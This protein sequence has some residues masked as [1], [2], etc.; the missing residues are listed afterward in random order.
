MEEIK[1]ILNSIIDTIDQKDQQLKKYVKKVR[2]ADDVKKHDGPGLP[3]EITECIIYSY[4]NKKIIWTP[5]DIKNIINNQF[6]K[7][8]LETIEET[9]KLL[10]DI[11]D[12]ISS[13]SI[14]DSYTSIQLFRTTSGRHGLKFNKIHESY[15]EKII[16]YF[17]IAMY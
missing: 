16:R 9:N 10:T 17:K 12:R 7:I 2:F 13:I 11:F 8:E 14:Y 4:F 6:G 15:L 3:T 5:L 1:N